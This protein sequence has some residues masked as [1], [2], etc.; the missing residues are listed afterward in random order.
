MYAVLLDYTNRTVLITGATRGLGLI[1]TKAFVKQGARVVF[2]GRD[3]TQLGIL[4]DAL[5][6]WGPST[7]YPADLTDPVSIK[8]LADDVVKYYESPEIIVHCAGG[9]LGKR[10][11]LLDWNDFS[12]LFHT[13]I[14]GAAEL[15]RLLLP[16]MP[17]ERPS[18]VVHVG[19]TT[20]RE[21]IGSVGYNTVKS[22]LAAYVRS[23]GNAFA[24]TKIVI[25]GILPGAFR[26]PHNSWDRMITRGDE[27][28][29]RRFV[30]DRLPRDQ[31]AHADDIVPLIFLLTSPGGSMMAG[32]CVPI[33]A[34]EG[35]AYAG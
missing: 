20:S 26:A 21:A 2:T 30:E 12:E 14:G 24:D 7:Y 6:H 4:R 16:A 15:N 13:N 27:A 8:R 3:E 31:M 23:L 22:A 18:Y 34:G 35:K 25:T 17:S 29:Y 10:G 1:V 11:S 5:S 33:D 32:S 19:S 28:I 9:G